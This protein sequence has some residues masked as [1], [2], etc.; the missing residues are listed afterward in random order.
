M[1]RFSW[2]ERSEKLNWHLQR[3]ECCGEAPSVLQKVATLL[4]SPGASP[5]VVATIATLL[6]ELVSERPV[7]QMG[8]VLREEDDIRDEMDKMLRSIGPEIRVS[9]FY[10]ELFSSVEFLEKHL[11]GRH[12]G[13]SIEVE[14]P[15]KQKMRR[16]IGNNKGNTENSV[17]SLA[18]EDTIQKMIQRV[19][20]ALQQHEEKLRSL[21]AQKIKKLRHQEVQRHLDEVYLQKEKADGQLADLK[22]QILTLKRKMMEASTNTDVPTTLPYK[23][24]EALAAV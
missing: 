21:E 13:E 22:K 24:D 8:R 4:Q 6:T 18:S 23:S 5:S 10:G 2:R 12:S 1:Q 15:A 14:T 7:K 9:G 3:I 19:E 11:G 20:Q 16:T 17:V